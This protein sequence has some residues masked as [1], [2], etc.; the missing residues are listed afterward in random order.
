MDASNGA[1]C[2]IIL[3]GRGEALCCFT[4]QNNPK[5]ILIFYFILFNFK[6]NISLLLI[7]S[8][9]K[10]NESYLLKLCLFTPK[11]LAGAPSKGRAQK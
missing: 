2:N 6:F 8:S 5:Y 11:S 9:I 3:K 1:R 4:I 7:F 10:F